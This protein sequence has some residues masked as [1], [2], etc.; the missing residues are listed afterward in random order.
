[1][2]C[3]WLTWLTLAGLCSEV[4]CGE[5][6]DEILKYVHVRRAVQSIDAFRK[7][8]A[9]LATLKQHATHLQRALASKVCS[10]GV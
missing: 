1:V 7:L 3:G 8:D 10:K 9:D 5:D 2:R 4:K 6:D